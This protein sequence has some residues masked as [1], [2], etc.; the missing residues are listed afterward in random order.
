MYYI[1]IMKIGIRKAGIRPEGGGTD[2]ISYQSKQT[3]TCPMR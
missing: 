3:K 1:K 2:N